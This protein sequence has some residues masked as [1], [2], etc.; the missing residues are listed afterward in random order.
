MQREL[1]LKG[2]RWKLGVG[3]GDSRQMSWAAAS[4]EAEDTLR[5]RVKRRDGR[6]GRSVAYD[7]AVVIMLPPGEV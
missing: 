6:R 2:R 7:G 3:Q 5:V 4:L 1:V